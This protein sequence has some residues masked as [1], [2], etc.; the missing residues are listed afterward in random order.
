MGKPTGFLIQR[1]PRG[2]RPVQRVKDWDEF[3]LH[4]DEMPGCGSRGRAAWTA[5]FLSAR[6][7]S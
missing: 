7:G 5:A 2:P 1:E 3:H 4:F 6:L